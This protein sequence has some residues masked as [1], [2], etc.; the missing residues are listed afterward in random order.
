L[1]GTIEKENT[2]TKINWFLVN[3]DGTRAI[4]KVTAKDRNYENDLE[5]QEL[6]INNSKTKTDAY[7]SI[8]LTCYLLE[9]LCLRQQKVYISE[10]NSNQI[11]IGSTYTLIDYYQEIIQYIS[12][13]RNISDEDIPESIM[14]NTAHYT[15]IDFLES[16]IKI[17][18][19]MQT[20]YNSRIS[21]IQDLQKILDNH[22]EKLYD[23][24][25]PT[26]TDRGF[27]DQ[28]LGIVNENIMSLPKYTT[29][30]AY[31]LKKQEKNYDSKRS[32]DLIFNLSLIANIGFVEKYIDDQYPADIFNWMVYDNE[33]QGDCLFASVKDALNG[34]MDA[35]N[36]LTDNPY[37]EDVGGKKIFT[38]ASLRKIVADNYTDLDYKNQCEAIGGQIINGKCVLYDFDSSINPPLYD[39][40]VKNDGQTLRTIEEVRDYISHPCVNNAGYNFWGDEMCIQIL[41]SILKIKF[42]IIDMTTKMNINRMEIGDLVVVLNYDDEDE[43]QDYRIVNIDR[44]G[45]P[46]YTVR[47][48]NNEIRDLKREDLEFSKN[49]IYSLIRINC[50]D[51]PDLADVKD[52]IFLLKTRSDVSNAEHYEFVRY[53]ETNNY[54]YEIENI[55]QYIKYFIYDSCYRFLTPESKEKGFGMILEFKK[56]FD[57]FAL[58]DRN[59]IINSVIPDESEPLQQKLQKYEQKM[60][61]YNDEYKKLDKYLNDLIT[62]D[63]KYEYELPREN[64][65]IRILSNRLDNLLHKM[66]K[67]TMKMFRIQEK[68]DEGQLGGLAPLSNKPSKEYGEYAASNMYNP[69]LGYNLGSNY[70]LG[71]NYNLGS[72]YNLGPNYNTGLGYPGPNYNYLDYYNRAPHPFNKQSYYNQPYRTNIKELSSKLAYYISIELELYPGTSVNMLQKS[73]LRCQ[74]T[75]ERIREA[76]SEIFGY[77]YR[78]SV[79]K[80]AYGYNYYNPNNPNNP[81]NSNNSK[82]SNNSNNSKTEKKREIKKNTSKRNKNNKN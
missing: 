72:N 28:C 11:S 25:F 2:D 61:L 21:V 64:K 13:N 30:S 75:F 56:I 79:L 32:M 80:E 65:E 45:T 51:N 6:F 66:D 31:W 18:N 29:R 48:L 82:N 74:N 59:R 35:T 7:D 76:Y 38:V 47:S 73:A 78:P 52:C 62:K 46:V 26:M 4:T 14:W 50:L 19:R 36:Q 43:D 69:G 81:N 24:L 55:P 41:E 16:K 39:L 23:I 17:T 57:N 60:N 22:C 3:S 67:I 5:Q 71:P 49:N 63:N 68:L 42:I 53:T 77:Q 10:E 54:V 44:R 9:I 1:R 33:G 37:T 70:N 34:E 8:M 58:L 20:I 27:L 15:S 40:L 12:V